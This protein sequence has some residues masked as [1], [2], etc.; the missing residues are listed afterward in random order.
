MLAACRYIVVKGYCT[1]LKHAGPASTSSST[2]HATGPAAAPAGLDGGNPST[3]PS[4]RHSTSSHPVSRRATIEQQAQQF[5]LATG[6]VGPSTGS[7]PPGTAAGILA[8]NS[9]RATADAP[10]ASGAVG[11]AGTSSRRGTAEL[12]GL[13]GHH[14]F[15]AAGSAAVLSGVA[16]SIGGF[17]SSPGSSRRV[18]GAGAAG[19]RR[20]TSE[21]V[22]QQRLAGAFQPATSL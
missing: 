20:V 1:L 21:Q 4:S 8:G 6:T 3:S 19:S 22:V 13:A 15:P 17:G 16:Q 7:M 14:T 12:P 9:R 10:R 5:A 18:T 2:T 11:P